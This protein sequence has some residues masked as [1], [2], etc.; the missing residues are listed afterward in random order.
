MAP[1]LHSYNFTAPKGLS[2]R[3]LF[4]DEASVTATEQIIIAAA[5]AKGTTTLYNA[6]CEPHVSDLAAM[7]NSMGAKI[8][9]AGSN[10]ITIE[11]VEKLAGCTHTVIG[12]H[13]EAGSFLALAAA[14][15]TPVT[16]HGTTPRHYWMLR[17]VFERLGWDMTV[18][19]DKIIMPGN[20][21]PVVK[22][23]FGGYRFNYRF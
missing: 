7:L 14:T 6:A 8:S 15:G 19:P 3:D 10:T 2:G 12:D 5:C 18:L 9:G 17:R 22:S 4:L 23:D 13:I 20:Q 21:N 1:A 16:L 11:G